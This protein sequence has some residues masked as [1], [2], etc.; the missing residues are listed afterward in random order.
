MAPKA[1]KWYFCERPYLV[2]IHLCTVVSARSQHAK[3]KKI[4]A[5]QKSFIKLEGRIGD[6]TF[7]KTKTGYQAREKGGVSGNRIATDP[8]FART[9]ENNAEFGRANAASK[10][11]RDAL[12][13]FIQL[14][15]D[16]RMSNRLNS[17]M[18]RVIK[19]DTVS[20]RGERQVL[21]ENLGILNRFGFNSAASLANTL[22]LKV[23]GSIDRTTGAGLVELPVLD[24]KVVIA[25]PE[26][27]THFQFSTALAAVDFLSEEADSSFAME[28]SEVLAIDTATEAIQLA[29]T[30]A[31]E[32]ELPLFLAFGIS[33]Y[34]EVNGKHYPLNN[35]A[36]N[37]L[38]IIK[39]DQG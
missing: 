39:V 4:M 26:G 27:A 12:R 10:R 18:L 28:E 38:S 31:P 23:S 1:N 3:K 20:N 7:Y 25:K 16:S 22:F 19:A 6:L 33:F 14:T 21:N 36:Y 30:L 29:P 15:S 9:R 24:P 5:Q 13:S 32:A 11:L 17:R 34:Q 35:G 8:K 2:L 37:A